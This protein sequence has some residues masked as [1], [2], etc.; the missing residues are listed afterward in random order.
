MEAAAQF[1]TKDRIRDKEGEV[2]GLRSTQVFFFLFLSY[3][4][5][6]R[7]S[8]LP[9]QSIVKAVLLVPVLPIACLDN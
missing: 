9:R 1:G 7:Y 3:L 4:S 8:C 2:D 6:Q 5:N